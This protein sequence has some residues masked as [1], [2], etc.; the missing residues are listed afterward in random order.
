MTGVGSSSE[1]ALFRASR[2]SGR[3][4]AG[5]GPLEVGP[6]PRH[7]HGQA[8]AGRSSHEGH[9]VELPSAGGPILG[10]DG[11]LAGAQVFAVLEKPARLLLREEA[12]VRQGLLRP[13]LQ[14]GDVVD[15]IAGEM[16]PAPAD[17]DAGVVLV[18]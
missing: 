18:E 11:P 16:S 3:P 14:G 12:A 10:P 1:R 4:G 17:L 2:G 7:A 8:P 13:L 5:F 6:A 9:A 15:L